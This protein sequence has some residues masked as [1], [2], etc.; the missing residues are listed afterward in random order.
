MRLTSDRERRKS[1]RGAVFLA[2]GV[3]GATG[4][5][6]AIG[7]SAGAGSGSLLHADQLILENGHRLEGRV[8][9]ADGGRLRVIVDEGQSVIVSLDEVAQRIPGEAP[10]DAFARRFARIPEDDR[11]EYIEL[12]RWGEER[13]L[14]RTARRAW[15]AVLA[16]DP[17]H[18]GARNRLGYALH[19]NRWVR[20]EE[21]EARGLKLFRGTFMTD[22]AIA[23]LRAGEAVAE[24]DALLVDAGHDNRFVREN[25]MLRVLS[26][27]DPALLPA[28]RARLADRD[29][30]K[31]M[32]VGRV[33]GNHPFDEW[34]EALYR[35][36]LDES[37]GEVRSAWS[38]VLRA[39]GRA[40]IGSWLAR[41]LAAAAT[42][43]G[44]GD[45]VRRRSLLV[46]MQSC[47][48]RTALP[49]LMAWADDPAWGP[50]ATRLIAA[51]LGV[52]EEDVVG[53][54]TADWRGWWAE[55][56]GEVPEDLGSGWLAAE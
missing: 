45:P 13:G 44:G 2:I 32:L 11:D 52:V 3:L 50:P 49:S 26:L 24:L 4:A 56:G 15:S 35:A 18:T 37:R 42:A 34:G 36:F 5:I 43:E 23:E 20:R 51:L 16:L 48:T 38:A 55:V 33:L 14:R 28:L 53:W 8:E 12:A 17:H 39:S 27:T 47:P 6:G 31:R 41:D 10:I 9:P 21:L 46:L 29:P 25:A 7:A 19:E 22:E 40:E 54:S 30:L 1:A